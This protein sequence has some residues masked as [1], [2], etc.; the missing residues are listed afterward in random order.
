MDE[1][2]KGIFSDRYIA[3]LAIFDHIREC[4]E[5]DN[6]LKAVDAEKTSAGYVALEKELMDLQILLEV[7]FTGAE[8]LKGARIQKFLANAVHLNRN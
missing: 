3:K 5:K 7:Y 2:T 1:I 6:H 8:E 4:L